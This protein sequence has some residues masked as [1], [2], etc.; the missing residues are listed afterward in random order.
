MAK[1]LSNDGGIWSR[2][3]HQANTNTEEPSEWGLP[4]I[5]GNCPLENKVAEKLALPKPCIS[6]SSNYESEIITETSKALETRFS[7]PCFLRSD[8]FGLISRVVAVVYLLTGVSQFPFN[9]KQDKCSSNI[10]LLSI[11]LNLF[12]IFKIDFIF[13]GILGS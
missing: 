2:V 1:L 12:L 6:P 9:T 13:R 5:L 7:I 4:C 10:I 8:D 11:L 3:I